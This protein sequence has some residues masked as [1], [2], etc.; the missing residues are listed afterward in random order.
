[1]RDRCLGMRNVD[2]AAI[3]VGG[4]CAIAVGDKE[5]FTN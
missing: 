5:V 3:A 2:Q 4:G 1:V